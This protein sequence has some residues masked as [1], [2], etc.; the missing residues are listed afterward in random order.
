MV[1]SLDSLKFRII[2]QSAEWRWNEFIHSTLTL[3]WTKEKERLICDHSKV[4]KILEFFILFSIQTLISNFNY[5][6][7]LYFF[8]WFALNREISFKENII[9]HTGNDHHQRCGWNLESRSSKSCC[10]YL[11]EIFFLLVLPFRTTQNKNMSSPWHTMSE[12]KSS[13]ASL[14][15]SFWCVFMNMLNLWEIDDVFLWCVMGGSRFFFY[16][17]GRRFTQIH[18][19]INK[20]KMLL[21]FS[22][23]LWSS[24]KKSEIVSSIDIRYKSVLEFNSVS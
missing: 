16:D 10:G 3:I 12:I 1:E 14:W 6:F 15:S 9:F 20:R 22:A 8:M 19:I 7:E 23:V 13:I 2:T 18:R 21:H 4:V 24:E 11:E 17:L 5:C